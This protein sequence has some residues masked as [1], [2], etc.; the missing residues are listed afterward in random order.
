M[1]YGFD[2]VL[3]L[4]CEMYFSFACWVWCLLWTPYCVLCV[5]CF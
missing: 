4:L 2:V 1:C 5:L 3:S